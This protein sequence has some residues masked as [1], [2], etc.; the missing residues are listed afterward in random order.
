MGALQRYADNLT[1]LP[2]AC[3]PKCRTDEQLELWKWPLW[4]LAQDA[5]G[6]HLPALT[7]ALKHSVKIWAHLLAWSTHSSYG[8]AILIYVVWANLQGI[9]N[10]ACFPMLTNIACCWVAD[11]EGLYLET[12]VSGYTAA[13]HAWHSIQDAMWSVDKAILHHTIKGCRNYQPKGSTRN[14]HKPY[15]L[16][17]M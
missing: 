10:L 12:T 16:E 17:L 2:S 1:P 6:K 14:K 15:T 9:S 8:S 4:P 5:S 11:M 13:L 3:F 7:E